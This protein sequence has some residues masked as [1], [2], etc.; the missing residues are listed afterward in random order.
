M[1]SKNSRR[2]VPIIV[3]SLFGI[4]SRAE[5]CGWFE[6]SETVRLALFRAEVKGMSAFRPFYYSA[7]YYNN[8]LPDVEGFDQAVNCSEWQK[9]LGKD[10]PVAD[11]EVILYKTDPGIFETARQNNTLAE[12]FAGNAFIKKLLT[13]G[14]NN[15]LKYLC[16]AKEM[17]YIN[18]ESVTRWESW[19]EKDTW[20]DFQTHLD[21]EL[22]NKSYD[23]YTDF[24]A[25]I[26]DEFLQKRY[27][28]LLL[29]LYTQVNSFS[30]AMALY[31][32]YFEG[33]GF[34]SI[35]DSWALLFKAMSLDATGGRLKA[36]Y[37]YSLVFDRS[38]EKKLI[39]MQC[40]NTTPEM[41]R[42]TMALTEDSHQKAVILA[43]AAFKNPGKAIKD[44]YAIDSLSPNCRYM[45]PLILREINKMEDWVL[46]P[47][48]TQYGPSV[49]LDK[50]DEWYYPNARKKNYLVD[51]AYMHE[52]A[53]F[54]EN[55]R[56]RCTGQE[57]DF[58]TL[59]L[60]HLSFI[61]DKVAEGS[62]YLASIS[63]MANPSIVQ[64][65]NIDEALVHLKTGDI[66]NERVKDE[67]L[68]CIRNLEKLAKNNADVYKNLYS[69]VRIISGE[70]KKKNDIAIA[71][72]LFMQSE[73]YKN[74]YESLKDGYSDF[75]GTN[76]WYYGNIAYFDRFAKV[77]D[78]D[79]IIRIISGKHKSLFEAYLC[80]QP[81]G[82]VNQYKDLKGTIAFRNN[83]L[84]VAYKTFAS[85][86]DS[87]WAQTYEYRYYLESNPF[88]PK[89]WDSQLKK[90]GKYNFVKTEFVK[91]LIDL[92][93]ALGK[94]PKN[95]A[96]I[97]LKLAHAYYN[98][99]YWGNSWMMVN[100]SQS[101]NRN[102]NWSPSDCLFGPLYD[103][104]KPM[105]ELN[106]FGCSI[107][108]QYYRKALQTATNNEQ[109]AIASLMLHECDYSGYL[110]RYSG[111]W[112]N[113]KIPCFAADNYL[114][115]FYNL[116]SGTKAF[117]E[118]H[119]PLLDEFIARGL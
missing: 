31:D 67:L 37:L 9:K 1:A 36:N 52:F 87:F 94:N 84:D 101:V 90:R 98:C 59:S 70:Y 19:D 92:N 35:V 117:R 63:K 89:S 43:M 10:I 47:S 42:E 48:Y 88:I 5:A 73:I 105:V 57:R 106:Y 38:D 115:D 7:Q 62:K 65:K 22:K 64:Q 14:N 53:T 56:K 109:K 104:Q 69:L 100:Y 13:K 27:A 4:L 18:T 26:K 99:S 20:S 75:Y 66:A 110:F 16:F 2:I 72:L 50:N 30:D 119:C 102:E 33:K 32:C 51:M 23:S 77:S 54:L 111:I 96:D 74:K 95:K 81:L 34:T 40:F 68:G 6:N 28:F 91:Q 60:A 55:Y 3:I 76:E 25:T 93:H 61:T 41:L 108:R 79:N 83:D 78:V 113:E 44:L 107:A 118:L 112:D 86:P 97:Y 12:T 49:D 46:T 82:T 21:K 80:S 11:I 45:A 15:F 114:K 39:A 116:Y 8:Y 29:R 58:I 71:G 103:T 17:E 24:I 85:M